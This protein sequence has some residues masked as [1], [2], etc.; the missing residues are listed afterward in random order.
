MYLPVALPCFIWPFFGSTSI[1]GTICPSHRNHSFYVCSYVQSG[2]CSLP[3]HGHYNRPL[4]VDTTNDNF[5]WLYLTMVLKTVVWGQSSRDRGHGPNPPH[6]WS[7][8]H[9]IID[10]WTTLPLSLAPH[11][12]YISCMW[13][14]FISDR[15]W[16]LH[17]LSYRLF[18]DSVQLRMAARL[19]ILLAKYWK[20]ETDSCNDL[21]ISVLS[22][23]L[24]VG[25]Q[26][27]GCC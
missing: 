23:N 1:C 21:V 22:I 9:L 13:F 3:D 25:L 10:Q 26:M 17:H 18:T 27:T 24:F 14:I 5:I 12:R 15:Q 7:P 6:T 19:S 4:V 20:S 8:T 2:N 16:S 11:L